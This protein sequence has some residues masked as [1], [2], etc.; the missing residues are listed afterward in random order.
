MAKFQ[1]VTLLLIS[2]L[3]FN[4]IF[5]SS[6]TYVISSPI[7]PTKLVI[8]PKYKTSSPFIHSP[9]HLH[10]LCI[11][12]LI[13]ANHQEFNVI[14]IHLQRYSTTCPFKFIYNMLDNV[15]ILSLFCHQGCTIHINYLILPSFFLIPHFHSFAYLLPIHLS[16]PSVTESIEKP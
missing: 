13:L 5:H 8:T 12:C 3:S 2:R 7:S 11:F 16:Y 6:V 10:L 15:D 4:T 9:I 1:S 14:D